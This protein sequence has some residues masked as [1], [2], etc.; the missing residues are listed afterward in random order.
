MNR[1]RCHII[2]GGLALTMAL[3]ARAQLTN[4]SPNSEGM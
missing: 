2:A 1:L 3:V 4:Y